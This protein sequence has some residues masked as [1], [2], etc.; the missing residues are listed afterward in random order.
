[1]RENFKAKSVWSFFALLLYASV[2]GYGKRVRQD[3]GP[4]FKDEGTINSTNFMR[5]P[6]VSKINS[7][8]AGKKFLPRQY[9]KKKGISYISFHFNA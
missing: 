5:F 2:L 3:Q 8:V 4:A 1:M 9:Q 7:V 6:C